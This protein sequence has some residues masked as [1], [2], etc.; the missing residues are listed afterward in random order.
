VILFV[1]KSYHIEGISISIYF[2]KT[3]QLLYTNMLDT[4]N[5]TSGWSKHY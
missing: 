1:I 2:S 3:P 5:S 4:K